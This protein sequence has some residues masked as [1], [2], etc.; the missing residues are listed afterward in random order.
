MLGLGVLSMGGEIRGDSI[1]FSGQ[2]GLH[3]AQ[4]C[5]YMVD[6]FFNLL[7]STVKSIFHSIHP[8]SKHLLPFNYYVQLVLKVFGHY[9][10]M[11]GEKRFN[12]LK[13]L[14]F[15][16]GLLSPRT[17]NHGGKYITLAGRGQYCWLFLHPAG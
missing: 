13:D 4:L 1:D 3:I 12:L 17:L 16:N 8:F 5:F 7:H 2:I 11:V 15:H 6:P 14:V 9:P 10:H